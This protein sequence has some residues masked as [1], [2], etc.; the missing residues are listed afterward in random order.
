MFRKYWLGILAIF[1][2]AI[3][4][5]S[6]YFS[7]VDLSNT[8]SDFLNRIEIVSAAL[9]WA[10]FIIQYLYN[11]SETIYVWVNSLRLW[12][13]N[14]TTKWN[15]TVDFYGGNLSN[16]LEKI[17]RVVSKQ[18]Q[19]AITWHK[20]VN[21][22]IV[23]MPGYT[24]RAIITDVNSAY[25]D[26]DQ[27]LTVQIS[28]LEL[29][30]KSFKTKIEN[31]VVPLLQDIG[32]MVKSQKQKYVAK[33]G[34]SSP[35]PYFGF[36]VRKLDLP[37]VVSFTCDI[38]ETSFGGHPQTVAVRKDRIEI[39]TDDLFAMQSLSFRYIALNGK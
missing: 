30:Y 4:L 24:I 18:N 35:N 39:V 2:L 38:L 6:V 8:I 21:S 17:N 15:F 23:N 28:N 19:K 33:I 9:G 37:K 5:I 3:A 36:F 25:D 16:A 29:P 10:L 26:K 11:K 27:T 1:L 7:S 31:E 22:L 14:E 32:N 13:A 12:L 20:D 34:F